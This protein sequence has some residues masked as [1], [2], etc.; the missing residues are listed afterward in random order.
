MDTM[1]AL[2]HRLAGGDAQPASPLL[3]SSSASSRSSP[4]GEAAFLIGV[5][6]AYTGRAEEGWSLLQSVLLCV[7]VVVPGLFAGFR[8]GSRLAGS[9]PTVAAGVFC[10]LP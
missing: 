7:A 2:R 3:S 9:V 8:K 5:D 1:V 4:S 6:S 10:S